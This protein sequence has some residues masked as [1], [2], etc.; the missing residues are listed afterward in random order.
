MSLS[1]YETSV[2]GSIEVIDV[3]FNRLGLGHYQ[4]KLVDKRSYWAL[5]VGVDRI[6]LD[7]WIIP[8][9]YHVPISRLSSFERLKVT[10]RILNEL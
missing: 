7:S 8:S 4:R 9:R 2:K 3:T 1:N 6:L 5:R 10:E